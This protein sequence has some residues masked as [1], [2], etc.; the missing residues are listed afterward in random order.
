MSLRPVLENANTTLNV[1]GLST[2]ASGAKTLSDELSLATLNCVGI[3]FDVSLSIGTPEASTVD[4]Y[5]VGSNTTGS[6]GSTTDVKNPKFLDSVDMN[7]TTPKVN[8]QLNYEQIPPFSKLLFKNNASAALTAA[9][10]T[11]TTKTLNNV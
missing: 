7:E 1:T 6:Y 9:T 2:L 4:V 11:Y 3:S 8:I 10:V 5:L